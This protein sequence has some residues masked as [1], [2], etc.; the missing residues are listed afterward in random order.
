MQV[1]KTYRF[2]Q[3]IAGETVKPRFFGVVGS[4]TLKRHL[5]RLPDRLMIR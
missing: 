1:N 4:I 5:Q 3:L 2:N